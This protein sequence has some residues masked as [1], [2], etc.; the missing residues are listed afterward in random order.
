MADTIPIS[1]PVGKLMWVN[2][3]GTGKDNFNKDFKEYVA[4]VVISEENSKELRDQINNFYVKQKG[5]KKQPKSLGFK[6]CTK[7]GKKIEN[8]DDVASHFAFNFKTRTEFKDGKTKKIAVYNSNAKKV[9][10]GD[11]VIGN[12]SEGA[13]SG[14]MSCY[15]NGPNSGVSLWLN[16]VQLTK[17]VEYESDA[18]VGFE[19]V[20]AEDA[21]IALED[22]DTGFKGVEETKTI[23][24]ARL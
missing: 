23:A 24:P 1:T 15:T 17:L 8:D 2:I 21:F 14:N 5:K 6:P 20:D 12:G 4:S 9:D 16:A 18:D 19:I 13:I 11:T 10:I 22:S 3:S 7:E